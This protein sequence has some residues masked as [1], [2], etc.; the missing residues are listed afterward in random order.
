LT[1]IS[2]GR[3]SLIR[4]EGLLA[5][6]RKRI[7]LLTALAPCLF[8]AILVGQQS[9]P[10]HGLRGI[11]FA[12]DSWSGDPVSTCVEP[13][14]RFA[15][16][17]LAQRVGGASPASAYWEGYIF[18]PVSARYRLSVAS[19]DGSWVYLDDARVIEN[20]G[21]HPVRRVER[22]LFLARGNH[23][24]IL[25]YFDAGG[26]ASLKFEWKARGAL[27]FLLP[28]ARLYPKPMS[29]GLYLGDKALRF[30]LTFARMAL[31]FVCLLL[32]ATAVHAARSMTIALKSPSHRP[33]VRA[34][35]NG[36]LDA[37]LKR[38][39]LVVG[40]AGGLFLSLLAIARL[41]PSR[42]L[43][44]RYYSNE[45][46]NGPPAFVG[47][48]PSVHFDFKDEIVKKTK[49]GENFSATWEGYIYAP[50][51]SSYRFSVSSDDGS[52]V[53]VDDRLLIDNGGIH[54]WQYREK[55]TFLSRGNHKILIRYFNFGGGASLDFG[56]K[57]A[58]S[59][60]VLT[61]R[62]YLYPRPANRGRVI[63]D[64][65]L[66][67]LV[68]FL[69]AALLAALLILGLLA[70]RAARPLYWKYCAVE[71]KISS[72]VGGLFARA[73]RKTALGAAVLTGLL[74]LILAL[75]FV[76]PAHGLRGRYYDNE[77]WTGPTV[78]T[79]LDSVVR[80]KRDT[81]VKRVG[82]AD[83]FSVIWEGY[84]SAPKSA[85]YRLSINSGSQVSVDGALVIG[86]EG[87]PAPGRTT[88]EIT[89]S[90]GLHRLLI[91][92][93]NTG[94]G[95]VDFD[96]REAG[97]GGASRPGLVF[98]PEPVSP[99]AATLDAPLS[100][101][102]VILIAAF[103]VLGFV[104]LILA[105]QAVF[106][107]WEG[108]G[109]FLF[110]LFLVEAGV[111]ESLVFSRRSTAVTG[112]DSYA[113][114]QGAEL[115]ARNGFLRTEYIDPL[116]PRIYRNFA[117]KPA[118]Q[119]LIFL[120]SPHGHYVYD[121]QKGSVYNVF[122]PG[123]SMLLYPLV[124]VG[125]LSMG[126][127]FL[128]FLNLGVL[129]LLFVLGTKYVNVLFGICLSAVTL[130]NV[131][132]FENTVLI[133]SDIPS[134]A[135]LAL[136]AFFL[137][138]NVCSFR[139]WRPLIAGAC[140]GFSVVVRYSNLAGALPLVYLLWLGFRADRRLS[141]LLKN[142]MPFAAGAFLFGAVPLGLYTH[143]LLGTFFRLVYEPLTQSQAR[144]VNLSTG[145]TYYL[146][147]LGTT[148]GAPGIA[149]MA[150]GLAAAVMRPKLKPAAILCVLG[151]LSFFLFYSFQ[152]I[153][154]E[155]YLMPT[156]PFLAALAGFGV[157][158]LARLFDRSWLAKGLI[159]ALCAG[160]P[161]LH[162]SGHYRFGITD[163]ESV[164]IAVRKQVPANAVVFCD[165]LSGS[166]RFYAGLPGY[167]FFWPDEQTLRDTI[168][169]LRD[170]NIPSYFFL[171]SQTALDRFDLL[172]ER[173]VILKES[174]E[175]VSRIR[176]WPLYRVRSGAAENGRGGE[177]R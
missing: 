64:T 156:F 7:L 24:L 125:G 161:L 108:L 1:D 96:C 88:K 142:L 15:K 120:L 38:K 63:G 137:Y 90:R 130:F 22:E 92:Y 28:P 158:S 89:L 51:N 23:P 174:V 157:L 36:L 45:S 86:D 145:V 56:W 72:R 79:G 6:V 73:R 124:K 40:V 25:R 138:R 100:V 2:R 123:T 55:E 150:V 164:S 147:S 17:D 153:R 135:L 134:L 27:G 3:H 62:P 50:A 116:I 70:A 114:L 163:E 126:F 12:N 39:F 170:Q 54:P 159:V 13:R 128:P 148:F 42:G 32:L 75:K 136:A 83:R 112:C 141:G 166:L 98:Y 107:R 81:L 60:G 80:F 77:S 146:K 172:T 4:G 140:F 102:S 49:S 99:A 171:D 127:F 47:L 95:G 129:I 16:D 101:L 37:A 143:R 21:I 53:S 14:I 103:L 67:Y 66:G 149:L 151:F 26:D 87:A 165:Q 131:H 97:K 162:S 11:Y 113:Y 104:S 8:L 91:R 69:K 160:F 176:G 10:D 43:Q 167:R 139:W 122:P 71:R 41:S 33:E 111:Y 46:W 133:M 5:A 74:I 105:V 85:L 44:A 84:V 35:L 154:N 132:V 68:F 94:E 119:K 82:G 34:R 65:V 117:G 93:R 31:L 177:G 52:W 169:F 118:D 61:P 19:D 57:M 48:E 58:G 78:A 106:P 173:N 152:S 109:V 20:S 110:C 168:V 144:G 9:S 30:F 18:V 76:V 115:M 29:L 175:L 121:L 155:R 59:M